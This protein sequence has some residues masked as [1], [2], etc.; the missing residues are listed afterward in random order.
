MDQSDDKLTMSIPEFAAAMGVSK[1]TAYD[2]A[3]RDALPVK[4]L[5]IGEKRMVVSRKAVLALLEGNDCWNRNQ[6]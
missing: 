6:G 2:L 5:R 1:A 4:V 3:K